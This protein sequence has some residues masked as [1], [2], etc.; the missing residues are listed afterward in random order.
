MFQ[1]LCGVEPQWVS[2]QDGEVP[3]GALEAGKSEDGEVF[4]IGRVNDGEKLMIGKVNR[5]NKL[6]WNNVVDWI[7]LRS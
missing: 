5:P 4:Y 2:A 1:I 6:S 3:P 7:D